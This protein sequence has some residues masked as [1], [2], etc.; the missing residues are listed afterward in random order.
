MCK[1]C[2][3]EMKIIAAITSPGQ[4]DVIEKVLRHMKTWD[5][6]WKRERRARSPPSA[7]PSA[8]KSPEEDP[9]CVGPIDPERSVEDYTVDPPWEDES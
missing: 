5:P 2:G 1:S 4:D 9:S 6:P 8:Q 3:K 7:D